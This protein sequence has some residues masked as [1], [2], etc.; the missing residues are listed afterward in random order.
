MEQQL[1]AV[2]LSSAY[3]INKHFH[4]GIRIICLQI[5]FVIIIK[6]QKADMNH[7]D[8][9][10]KVRD[11]HPTEYYLSVRDNNPHKR[12]RQ[13]G[14]VFPID[15][16]PIISLIFPL[17]VMPPTQTFLPLQ[18]RHSFTWLGEGLVLSHLVLLLD[19]TLGNRIFEPLL[20]C[21]VCVTEELTKPAFLFFWLPWDFH[22]FLFD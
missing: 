21:T 12:Q 7:V 13:S 4:S 9:H 14:Q 16:N 19:Q 1:G 18:S 5:C 17:F 2:C 22:L 15:A 6:I 3:I 10:S 11:D 8:P 20:H